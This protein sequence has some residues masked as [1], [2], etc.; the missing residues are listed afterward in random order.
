MWQRGS[1][2]LSPRYGTD[3]V[4]VMDGSPA[5]IAE[6]TIRQRRRLAEA[7]ASFG[8]DEWAHPSRCD[9]WSCRDVIVHLETT[10]GFWGYSISSGVSGDPTQL[11]ATFDPVAS[12]AEMVTGSD[13][14][15][16]EVAERFAASTDA[17]VDVL[18][19]LGEDDWTAV[20]EAPPGH[21]SVSAVTHHALWDSWVHERDVLIPLGRTP[22][23]ESDE[24]AASLRYAAALGPAFAVERGTGASG[25][26]SV[27]A[28]D[29][30]LSLVVEI[31]GRASVRAGS[32]DADLVLR[33]DAVDLLEALSRRR[34][35]DAEVPPGTAWM[36][37]GVAEVFDQT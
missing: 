23:L 34:P 27:E 31:D 3:P 13:L 8:P 24:V 11:L 9:G 29:P 16:G 1:M 37:D 12:P 30:T 20:A 6:P 22:E 19:S 35:L 26:L 33:G 2:Q 21:L 7:L 4:I 14:T 25:V 5:A 36:L 18:T 32:A 10:N 15:G 17:L 28:T